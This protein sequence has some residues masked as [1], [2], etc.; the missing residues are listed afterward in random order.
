MAGPAVIAFLST[1]RCGTQWLAAGLDAL[2]PAIGVEHEPI[3]PLY[4]P[5]R[6]FRR[7]DDPDAMLEV[8]EVAAH[9]RRIER[10]RRPY[11]ETGWPLFAALPL[12]AARLPDRLRIVHLTRH[13]VPSALSHL[14]HKSYADSPRDDPYTRLATLGPSDP[15]V[16]Q[17]HYADVW[18]RFSPYEKCLFWWTEVHRFGLELPAKIAPVPVL[19]IKSEEILSGKREAMGPLLE[20]MQLPWDE[21]WRAHAGRVVDRWHH[22]SDEPV[23]PL[24]VHRHPGTVEVAG[25]LGYDLDDLDL[26]ALRA[27]YRGQPDPGLDRVGRFER[28]GI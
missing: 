26:P 14:A 19:R 13:P 5:R 24:D 12:L 25:E 4:R 18:D 11:I 6:Y 17:S 2:Y 21:R 16:F 9:L 23:D 8:P 20:F 22:H 27:R 7:Y 28:A 3:G 1:G 10:A 15:R